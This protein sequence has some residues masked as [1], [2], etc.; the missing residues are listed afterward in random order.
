MPES[1]Y[2]QFQVSGLAH[3]VAVSGAHLSIVAALVASML[4]ALRVPQADIDSGSNRVARCVSGADRYAR[5]RHSSY[6]HDVGRYDVM[7][8]PATGVVVI[9][10]RVLHRRYARARCSGGVVV[11]VRAIGFGHAWDR[12]VRS[13]RLTR[14]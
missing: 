1:V 8:G 12:R 7:D 14:G 3:V 11:L 10:A 13:V 9:C 2:H 6:A 4:G 5:F